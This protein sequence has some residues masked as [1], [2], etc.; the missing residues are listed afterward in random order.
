MTDPHLSDEELSDVIDDAAGPG[1]AVHLAECG[2]CS[3]HLATLRSMVAA[4]AIPPPAPTASQR[5]SAVAAAMGR[6]VGQRR[7]AA[8]LGAAAAVVALVLGTAAIASRDSGNNHND[9]T[10]AAPAAGR[11][12]A[13][14]NPTRETGD[15]GDVDDAAA[16]HELLAARLGP[17]P[18]TVAETGVAADQ[19]EGAA[20]GQTPCLTEVGAAG[21]DSLGSPTFTALLRYQQAP[22]IVFVYTASSEKLPR[23]VFVMATADGQLLVVQSF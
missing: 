13:A 12:S 18:K 3:A 22:A 7:P 23:R 11:E 9:A 5:A 16:L 14:L 4:V 8:W 15:L 17:A 19:A 21:A 10:A 1:A 20:T 2:E 6:P